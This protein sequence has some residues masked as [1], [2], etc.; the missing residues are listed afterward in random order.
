MVKKSA[1]ENPKFPNV[2]NSLNKVIRMVLSRK[3][4][5][6]KEGERRNVHRVN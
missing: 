4:V 3:S 1:L 2:Q 6:K 5:G